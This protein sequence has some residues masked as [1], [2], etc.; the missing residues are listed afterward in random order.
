MMLP[1]VPTVPSLIA[2]RR[3]DYLA[4]LK[5]AD[6]GAREH[7]DGEPEL[8]SMTTLLEDVVMRQLASAID[9]LKR[10]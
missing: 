2:A 1:G 7:P 6:A 9:K 10:P 3:D 4:A 5:A 8:T